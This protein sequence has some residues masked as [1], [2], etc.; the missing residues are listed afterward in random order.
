MSKKKKSSYAAAGVYIDEMMSALTSVKRMVKKTN[1][2]GVLSDIGSFGGLFAAPGKDMALVASAE[3][4]GTK[5]NVAIMAKKHD[6][7]GQDLINHCVN[8]IL[9][10]GARPLFF[11]DY[12][13]TSKLKGKVFEDDKCAEGARQPPF[14]LGKPGN[15]CSL[16]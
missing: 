12:L 10:Q 7:V 4:V 15:P 6:T 14:R 2:K 13:G 8:D 3:G 11:L 9:V 16:F 1:T 5:L